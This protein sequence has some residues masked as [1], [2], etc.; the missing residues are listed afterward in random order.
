MPSIR[1]CSSS[2][3]V[4]FGAMWWMSS[5]NRKQQGAAAAFRDNLL[6]GQEVMTGSGMY[7]TVVDVEGEVVILETAPGAQPLVQAGDRQAGRAARWTS[8]DDEREYDDA[9]DDEL[10]R[11]R[12]GRGSSATRTSTRTSDEADEL[13]ESD[14]DASTTT[15]MPTTGRG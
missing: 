8:T 15:A 4:L 12:V 11:G 6:P 10:G 14:E 13:R 1:R 9:E 3:A 2:L 5:R 7:G